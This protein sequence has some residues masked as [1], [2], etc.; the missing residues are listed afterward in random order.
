M[1]ETYRFLAH[2][3]QSAGLLYFMAVF[4]A[5]CA[6]ALWPRN[7]ARFEEAALIPLKED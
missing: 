7:K 5:V 3:A 2:L 6:Y 1:A 4:L